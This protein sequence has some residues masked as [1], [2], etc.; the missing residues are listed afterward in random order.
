MKPNRNQTVT[1]TEHLLGV[2]RKS[3]VITQ[4]TV[5]RAGIEP[6][7]YSLRTDSERRLSRFLP[8]KTTAD[9]LGSQ[10]ATPINGNR[11]RN[12]NVIEV[13]SIYDQ[14]MRL[15]VQVGMWW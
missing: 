11:N 4:L 12:G 10:P 9:P 3:F 13:P 1:K 14:P 7:T 2:L 8:L 6:A 15:L 5:R